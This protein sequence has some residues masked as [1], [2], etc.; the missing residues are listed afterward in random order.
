M[1]GTVNPGNRSSGVHKPKMQN[2]GMIVKLGISSHDGVEN[3]NDNASALA[4]MSKDVTVS[5]DIRW[6]SKKVGT[7]SAVW[8]PSAITPSQSGA[9]VLVVRQG[10]WKEIALPKLNTISS[11]SP[12]HT[13]ELAGSGSRTSLL[14]QGDT[15]Y[16]TG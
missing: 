13:T 2:E 5:L 16:F 4:F 11:E 3:A 8:K 15:V 6:G 9:P 10:I 14:V 12:E 1:A 7:M